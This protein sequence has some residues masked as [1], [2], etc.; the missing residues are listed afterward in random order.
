MTDADGERI[1]ETDGIVAT[2][3]ETETERLLEFE[4]SEPTASGRATA[5]GTAA[6]AQ[7][8]EGYAMLKVRPTADGD[9]LERYYGFDMALDHAAELLGVSPQDLPIPPAAD[10]MG[11]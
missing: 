5:G 7:N 3:D 1:V 11:M 4:G 6:I 10:D 9:E 2:Y 8:R